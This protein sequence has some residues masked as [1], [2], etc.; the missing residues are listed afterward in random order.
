MA[1][2]LEEVRVLQQLRGISK[3][4]L[5]SSRMWA[6]GKCLAWGVSVMCVWGGKLETYELLQGSGEEN[7]LW[8][9]SEQLGR[10][11]IIGRLQQL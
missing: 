4:F 10:H 6:A 1:E 5:S 9:G 8:E 7:F 3:E 2:K 11:V